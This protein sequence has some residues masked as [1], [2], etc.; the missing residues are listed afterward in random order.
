MP[1]LG[2]TLREYRQRAGLTQDEAA[3]AAGISVRTLRDLEQDR[4]ARPR[5]RSVAALAEVLRMPAGS[6]ERQGGP[7]SIGILGPLLVRHGDT[8]VEPAGALPRRLLGLLALHHGEAVGRD[9]IVDVLWPEATPASS[10]NLMHSYV[11]T[12]RRW[13]EP[14]RAAGAYSVLVRAGDGYRLTAGDELDLAL[15]RAGVRAAREAVERQEHA[16]ADGHLRTALGLWRG[17]LLGD[18]D[19]VLGGLGAAAAV[20]A[21]RLEA[22]LLYA[23]LAATRGEPGRAAAALQAIAEDEPLHEGLHVR[24]ITT[25]AASGAQAAALR[26]Y[27]GIRGR[28]ADELGVDPTAELR[29]AYQEVLRGRSDGR[30]VP[31]QLP[32]GGRY[33]TGRGGELAR[34]DAVAD[35][36]DPGGTAVV[37]SAVTGAAGVGKTA[38]AL[39]WAHRSA[40]R[41]TDGQLYV[42][43]RG[44]DPAGPADPADALRALLEALGVPAGDLPPT[45]ADRSSLLR[46]LLARRRILLLLDNARD[47]EQV[48]PLLPGAAGCLAL[49]TSRDRMTGLVVTDGAVP[50]AL[51]L[52]STGEARELLARRLGAARVAADEE[53][54]LE[55]IERCGYLPLAL[56]VVAARAATQP[57]LELSALAAEL[58][59]AR[60]DALDGGDL[61][62]DV[63]AVFSW[64]FEALPP[65]ARDLFPLLAIHPGTDLSLAAAASLAGRDEK[66]TAEVL[67]ELVRVSLLEESGPGRFR[68]HDLLHHY[69]LEQAAGTEVRQAAF[70][71]LVD[72]YGRAAHAAD[73]LMFPGRQSFELPAPLDGVSVPELSGPED[74]AAWAAA[75]LP[76]LGPVTRLAAEAGLDDRAW[77]LSWSAT[78]MRH[79]RNEFAAQAEVLTTAIGSAERLGDLR[80]QAISHLDL[81]MTFS[82]LH[83]YDDA[84]AELRRALSIAEAGGDSRTQ[85]RAYLNLGQVLDR[86]GDP[87]AALVEAEKALVL[88]RGGG[89]RIGEG[90]ALNA[91][92]WLATQ[93]GDHQRGL[94]AAQ[95]SL[96]LHEAAGDA[97]GTAAALDSVGWAHFH[98]GEYAE[99]RDCFKRALPFC[100][101]QG[102]HL[103]SAVVLEH[104][105]DTEHAA[106]DQAAAR[107]ALNEAIGHLEEIDPAQAAKLREKGYSEA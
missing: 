68:L 25:L 86:T 95:D 90:H 28:L 23:D 76:V 60:L 45:V 55:I 77:Q 107:D 102:D 18:A 69:A 85:G 71:R 88:F 91:V 5:R 100:L 9:R 41:F 81:G 4:N 75:E 54:T 47:A 34:L 101:D 48:R 43:L 73:R 58:R 6:W 42:N 38:L 64:T 31:A 74:A 40:A 52:L 92:G 26:A 57:G 33:F 11:A 53:A 79:M 99:A 70:E 35:T 21:E 103:L 1:S 14:G 17:R 27:E 37:I 82:H 3:A 29:A 49:V 46:S 72:H 16:V 50:V 65:A 104:L 19:P 66:S 106:G 36:L 87:R 51:D 67:A 83:R 22:T 80:R 89:D 32:P 94:A 12:V 62:S 59:A 84:A 39:H 7:L 97:Y 98:L 105:A 15:F 93:I 30:P 44:F 13:L 2:A 63:R 20:A 56:A 24:L 96:A 8:D 61:P 78:M 10:Q